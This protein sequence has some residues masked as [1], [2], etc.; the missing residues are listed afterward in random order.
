MFDFQL[1]RKLNQAWCFYITFIHLVIMSSITLS[2]DG[3]TQVPKNPKIIFSSDRNGNDEIYMMNIDGKN[4]RNLTNHPGFDYSPAWSPD[5]QRIAFYSGRQ[6]G[7]GLYMMDADGNNQHYL[8]PMDSAA[9]PAWSPDGKQIAFDCPI[10]RR[11]DI[12]VI[13]ANGGEFHNLTPHPLGDQPFDDQHP[14]WSPDG[15]QIAFTSDRSGLGIFVMDNDGNNQRRL[16][17][18][19]TWDSRPAWAPDGKQIA[20]Q[21]LNNENMDIYVMKVDGTDRRRLTRDPAHDRYPSWSPDG[22]KILFYSERDGR[23]G[24]VYVMDAH[25]NNQQNL[26][27]HL[28]SDGLYGASW[29]D[30]RFALS[31]FPVGKRIVSWGRLKLK[32]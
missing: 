18:R 29:F 10:G 25:G 4:P 11:V 16:T 20:F 2:N 15:K 8:A 28:M 24:E 19:R 30:P 6:E 31:V 22:K 14:T 26:T 12:C 27:N 21:S 7:E 32:K 23:T 17:P 1:N 3:W 13:A 9:N 5:G